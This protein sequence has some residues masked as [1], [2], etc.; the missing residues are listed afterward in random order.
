MFEK[1]RISLLALLTL[2]AP[3]SL[4]HAQDTPDGLSATA[5][6]NFA[7]QSKAVSLIQASLTPAQHKLDSHIARA[8]PSQRSRLS[9]SLPHLRALAA[10][11][12][13][14]LVDI[15]AKVTPAVLALIAKAGGQV[16]SSFPDENAIRALLTPVQAEQVAGSNEVYSIFPA[17]QPVLW[18]GPKTSEGDTTHKAA[19]ARATY[20]AKGAGIKVGV[21]SDGV[22]ALATSQAAG[23]LG[24]V[25]IIRN[26]AGVAQK[27]T[28]SEGVAML[29]IVH[30]LAPQAEL[31]FATGSSGTAS[32]A[33]NI[34][35]LQKAGCKVIVDDIAY[36][37][38]SNYQEDA[39]SR[40]IRDVT[41]LGALYLTAA[42]NLGSKTSGETGVWEG[43]FLDGGPGDTYY[44]ETGPR[45]H[46]FGGGI[47]DRVTSARSD[48]GT[49]CFLQWAD[50]LVGTTWPVH[51]NYDLLLIDS[52]GALVD[53]SANVQDG[54]IPPIE[55]LQ[56]VR[57]GDRLVIGKP[58][59]GNAPLMHVLM[60]PGTLAK[61]TA[62]SCRGHNAAQKALSVAAAPAAA[63]AQP[64]SP[65]GPFPN[66]FNATNKVEVFSSDGPRRLFF[67]G[68]GSPNDRTLV[69][70][71]IAAADGVTTSVA[72]F[73]PF[74]G[75]SAAA[76]HA[77]AIAALVWS[78]KPT[79]AA[80]RVRAALLGSVIDI[81]KTG[82][83]RDSGAGIV[84]A[85]KAVKAVQ[86]PAS[87]AASAKPAA[88]AP[89]F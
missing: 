48:G 78:V 22:D 21:L 57:A 47:F 65:T 45:L 71:D 24:T 81:M 51:H 25:T 70:P 79:M 68:D 6:A 30:D 56:S 67:N 69:K 19:L 32:M 82:V 20:G 2:T 53:Y 80:T 27:G 76:P 31:F 35:L 9:A 42:G 11:D 46:D 89:A 16:E 13:P 29:E 8:L 62:G 55:F 52:S 88:S 83:D 39:I 66:P 14:V 59:P 49:I 84:M 4:A 12:A 36:F 26:G 73:K 54:T 72:G 33:N 10:P 75:T 60:Y 50:A 28:G 41:N 58:A 18:A 44:G 87:P 23:E 40:A 43:K 37:A 63:A 3:L 15:R 61:F 7:R 64:G 5:Q 77:A 85:T 34:R 17:D 38:E 86:P 1:S 74:F